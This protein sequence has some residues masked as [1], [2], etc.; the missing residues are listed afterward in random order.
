M[1]IYI[2]EVINMRYGYARV[3]H[4]DQKLDR[5]I[6]LL[7]P[8][9]ERERDIITDKVS[10]K[11]FER[12]GYKLL[13]GTDSSAPLLRE[14]DEL[15]ICSLDRLG[16]NSDELQRE[17]HRLTKTMGVTIRVLD[18]PFLST[19]EG[20]PEQRLVCDIVLQLLC[21]FAQKEREENHKRQSQGYAAMPVNA[22]GKRI[23]AKTGQP[24]GRPKIEYPSNWGA[25]YQRWKAGEI[26]AVQAMREANIKRSSFYNLVKKYEKGK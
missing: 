6:E 14:G 7:K 18:M 5:Q 9:V 16:R 26:T 20:G 17:W 12:D 11:N 19:T 10:G 8:Y 4:K 23:S 24:C 15:I 25:V 21:Y 3:S 22:E 2:V 13:T 1:W